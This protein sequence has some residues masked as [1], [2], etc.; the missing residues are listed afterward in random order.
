MA[1]QAVPDTVEVTVVYEQNLERITNTFHAKKAGGYDQAA[2]T[3]LA[4]LVDDLV[5]T[6]LLPVMSFN[7]SYEHT[8][9]RG[10]AVE[11]D[12]FALNQDGVGPGQDVSEGLPN[13]VTVSIKK[14]S[15]F[16]GR[17]ARGR[18]YFVALPSNGL[19]S[20]EN[21]WLQTTMDDVLE[22]VEALRLGVLTGPWVPVIVSRFTAGA[23]RPEGVTFDWISSV[24]VNRNVD[25]QRGRLTR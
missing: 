2:I 16:T 8:E 4:E 15:G 19:A 3:T 6:F 18:W 9:V 25:S 23:P 11:N 1:F 22:A 21:Q 14:N 24:T 13:N 10:L 17:S 7:A 12:L 20:N 5:Q